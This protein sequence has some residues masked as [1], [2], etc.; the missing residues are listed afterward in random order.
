MMLDP[1]PERLKQFILNTFGDK[2]PPPLSGPTYAVHADGTVS[3]TSTFL[4][5]I[6]AC[7]VSRCA[8]R[9]R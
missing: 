8:Y 7:T 6:R 9:I 1:D 2:E 4:I 5:P 3:I